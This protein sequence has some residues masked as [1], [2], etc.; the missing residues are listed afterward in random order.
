MGNT[1]SLG[2][3]LNV[4]GIN[5]QYARGWQG[6]VF[7]YSRTIIAHSEACRECC[8]DFELLIKQLFLTFAL[9]NYVKED[10][11][12]HS[13]YYL[14]VFIFCLISYFYKA[15]TFFSSAF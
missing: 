6:T 9:R 1:P 10:E 12:N 14:N 11:G 8:Q 2:K 13:A 5:L 15:E 7:L 3:A 4:H